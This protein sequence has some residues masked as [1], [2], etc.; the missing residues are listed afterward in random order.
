VTIRM[1]LLMLCL[2]QIQAP[3]HEYGPDD[4]ARVDASPPAPHIGGMPV[5]GAV[6][7]RR[8]REVDLNL[9]ACFLA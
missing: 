3:H 8:V 1:V 4:A 7:S 5:T 6:A 2:I 9:D